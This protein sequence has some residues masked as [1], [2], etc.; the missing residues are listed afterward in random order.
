MCYSYNLTS[1][2]CID[3]HTLNLSLYI[4]SHVSYCTPL[5]SC[6]Y[7]HTYIHIH[8][9][10]H[11]SGCVVNGSNAIYGCLLSYHIIH[12]PSLP[13]SLSRQGCLGVGGI[14]EGGEGALHP[15]AAGGQTQRLVHQSQL[16]R[17]R[18]RQGQQSLATQQTN[19]D[20]ITNY[21]I[22]D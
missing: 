18:P 17:T 22:I 21:V 4:V 12:P 13:L 9:F 14:R 2:E 7:I 10:A 8:T 6:T 20:V 11:S 15:Q 3:T 19:N 5:S 16:V 1:N